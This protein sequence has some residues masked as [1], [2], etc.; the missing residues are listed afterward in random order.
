MSQV[1]QEKDSRMKNE[2]G[3]GNSKM[4]KIIETRAGVIPF[5]RMSI[6]NL[7]VV[8]FYRRVEK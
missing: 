4:K 5:F 7:S 1:N 3:Y 6:L 2:N 8:S